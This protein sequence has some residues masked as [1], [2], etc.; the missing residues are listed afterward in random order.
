MCPPAV[1]SVGSFGL[2]THFSKSTA[3]GSAR[4]IPS[5]TGGRCSL[6]TSAKGQATLLPRG[7]D[8][9]ATILAASCTLI[10]L[11]LLNYSSALA[12][13][14]WGMN[15]KDHGC[16]DALSIGAGKRNLASGPV[17]APSSLLRTR[18]PAD[19][20]DT[21]DLGGAASTPAGSLPPLAPHSR[22]QHGASLMLII[23]EMIKHKPILA[24]ATAPGTRAFLLRC[25]VGAGWR[26][27]RADLDLV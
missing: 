10:P 23:G 14:R 18:S 19:D 27:R 17:A 22:Q 16:R 1:S 20:P 13:P 21:A 12:A 7:V 15:R 25:Q 2:A 24:R 11:I 3:P 9:E 4:N 8:G 6:D 26:R 5:G